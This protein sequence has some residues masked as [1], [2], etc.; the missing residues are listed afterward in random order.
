MFYIDINMFKKYK[1]EVIEISLGE[2][3]I[4]GWQIKYWVNLEIFLKKFN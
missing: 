3:V 1:Q 2:F 4:I